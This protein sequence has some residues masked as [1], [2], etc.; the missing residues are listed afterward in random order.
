[1][2]FLH[3]IVALLFVFLP[4]FAVAQVQLGGFYDEANSSIIVTMT[5]SVAVAGV[6]FELVDNPEAFTVTG[7]SSS[8]SLETFSSNSL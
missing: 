6:Q 5:N 3:K 7:V 8:T 4:V 1:M 2:S